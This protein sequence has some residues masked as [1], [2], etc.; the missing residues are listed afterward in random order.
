MRL[1]EP[2]SSIE[3]VESDLQK[4]W[5]SWLRMEKSRRLAWA[6]FVRSSSCAVEQ[7]LT[8]IQAFDASSTSYH[9]A[10]SLLSMTEVQMDLPCSSDHWEAESTYAWAALHPWTHLLPVTMSFRDTVNKLFDHTGSALE[11]VK[12][13]YHRSL[14]VTCLART[15]WDMRET[16]YEPGA[17]LPSVRQDTNAN[18]KA[19]IS[20]LNQFAS[21]LK[22]STRVSTPREF[23]ALVHRMYIIRGGDFLTTDEAIDYMYLIWEKRSR[24]RQA[25]EH[26]MQWALRHPEKVRMAAYVGAQLLSIARQFPYNHPREP[27]QVFH[28][29]LVLWIMAGLLLALPSAKTAQV[30][31]DNPG[32]RPN[33][34]LVCQ[35]DWLGADD[36]PEGQALREWIDHGG[37]YIV[38]MHGVPHLMSERGPQQVLDQT[39]S[40]L[41][42]M[43]VWGISQPFLNT[44]LRVLHSDEDS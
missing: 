10:R 18:I 13:E 35:L 15:C 40:L 42:R 7:I 34:P 2:T 24:A 38:R 25:Q 8:C 5:E 29:G 31:S 9:N 12:D 17:H 41:R 37:D 3:K 21:P 43:P 22:S 16:M 33:K 27:Y 20:I 11:K 1:F 23:E 14:L 44:V 39:V 32:P 4:R 28:G 6:I 19:T 26:L 36:A 30:R